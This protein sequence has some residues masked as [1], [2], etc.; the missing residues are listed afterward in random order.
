MAL[1]QRLQKIQPRTTGHADIA[2][3]HLRYIMAQYA[4]RIICRREALECDV[5]ACQGFFQHTA[6]RAVIVDNPDRFHFIHLYG[7]NIAFDSGSSELR[8]RKQHGKTRAPWLAVEFYRAMMLA[9]IVLRQRQPKPVAIGASRYQRVKN[10]VLQFRRDAGAVVD[11]LH[12]YR[13]A[14]AALDQRHLPGDA[15]AQDD[16]AVAVH[17]LRGVAH[18]VEH[19]LD[20]LFLVANQCRQAGVI[21]ALYFHAL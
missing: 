15:R 20:Q 14:V 13:E 11:D 18:D 9:D 2:D 12:H 1:M 5:F 17:R 8:K 7:S 16:D 6:D 10:L 21:V 19:D 4:Q 3:H